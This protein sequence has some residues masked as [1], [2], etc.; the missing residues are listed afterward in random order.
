MGGDPQARML[1]FCLANTCVNVP[2]LLTSTISPPPP[3]AY[4]YSELVLCMKITYPVLALTIFM[5]NTNMSNKYLSF[6]ML[7]VICEEIF[8]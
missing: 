1:A 6:L 8:H 5:F 3:K 4:I 2:K 7:L